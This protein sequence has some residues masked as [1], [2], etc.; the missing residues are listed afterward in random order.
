MSRATACIPINLPVA[1]VM[2]HAFCPSQTSLPDLVIAGN[3]M[4]EFSRPLAGLPVVVLEDLRAVVGA[5][6]LGE[7]AADHFVLLEL[8]HPQRLRVDET[9]IAFGIGFE[10]HVGRGVNEVAVAILGLLQLS[11]RSPCAP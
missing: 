11:V 7:A 4:Y 5:N 3:S 1:S 6:E 2:I 10:D 8:E 9:E